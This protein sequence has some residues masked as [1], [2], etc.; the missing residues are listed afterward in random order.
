MRDKLELANV[1]VITFLLALTAA[2][3]SRAYDDDDL[4]DIPHKRYERHA[5]AQMRALTFNRD[6]AV[7]RIRC[8]TELRL[9][10]TL[11]MHIGRTSVIRRTCYLRFPL[12]IVPGGG[13]V[14]GYDRR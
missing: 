11:P 7:Q 3:V 14:D 13:Y 8:Q 6:Q 10:E 9:L 1:I 12:V 5:R 2:G 4:Y